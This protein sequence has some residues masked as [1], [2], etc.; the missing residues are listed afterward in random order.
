[1]AI[2]D[3]ERRQIDKWMDNYETAREIIMLHEEI[4]AGVRTAFAVAQR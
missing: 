1:L 3:F 4:G 2:R